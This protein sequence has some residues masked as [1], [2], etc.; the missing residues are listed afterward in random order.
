ML[1]NWLLCPGSTIQ[2]HPGEASLKWILQTKKICHVWQKQTLLSCALVQTVWYF[3]SCIWILNFTW[4]SKNVSFFSIKKKVWSLSQVR[5]LALILLIQQELHSINVLLMARWGEA[6]A[7]AFAILA[8]LCHSPR[9]DMEVT[10]LNVRSQ[11]LLHNLWQLVL[12]L[13]AE[14][15]IHFDRTKV[16]V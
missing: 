3:S 7:V 14:F 5:I 15:P 9:T 6:V 16:T 10:L 1:L 13:E 2:L 4:C 8:V 12:S 11:G